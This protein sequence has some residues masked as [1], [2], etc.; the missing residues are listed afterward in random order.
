[1]SIGYPDLADWQLPGDDQWRH[2]GDPVLDDA[3]RR[4]VRTALSR[5]ASLGAPVLWL[6]VAD[7]HWVPE[8]TAPEAVIPGHG[9]PT[10]NAPD[11]SR[12]I[13]ELNREIVTSFP[14]VRIAPFRQQLARK[15]DGRVPYDPNVRFDGLHLSS[16]ASLDLAKT[17]LGDE[18][19]RASVELKGAA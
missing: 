15:E 17:W 11:R 9:D 7:A 5:L 3:Y 19:Y 10:T 2:L 14:S 16:E 4:D 8:K 18:L 12:R 6:D 13:N 1:M